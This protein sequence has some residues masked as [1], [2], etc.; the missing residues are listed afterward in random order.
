MLV[1]VHSFAASTGRHAVQRRAVWGQPVPLRFLWQEGGCHSP[2]V[3][4][5]AATLPL[6]VPAALCVRHEGD[7]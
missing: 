3:S 6:H 7:Y 4:A 2:A 1:Q 5:A